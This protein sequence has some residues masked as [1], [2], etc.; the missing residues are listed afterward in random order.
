MRGAAKGWV[1]FAFDLQNGRDAVLD[2]EALDQLN[3]GFEQYY[4]SQPN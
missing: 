2:T 4:K 1:M 3:A